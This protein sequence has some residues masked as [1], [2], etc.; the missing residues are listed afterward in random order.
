MPQVWQRFDEGG[1]SCHS[2][3][4]VLGHSVT[5]MSIVALAL[6]L[7]AIVVLLAAV[8][9][10]V[11]RDGYGSVPPP[12]SHLGWDEAPDRLGGRLV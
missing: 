7:L 2:W 1:Q 3:Q 4:D 10:T 12:R 11:H 8:A 6:V 9:V 5:A